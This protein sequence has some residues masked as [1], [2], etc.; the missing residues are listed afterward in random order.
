MK[1]LI[2]PGR[3]SACLALAERGRSGAWWHERGDSCG[4]PTATFEPLEES[5][6]RQQDSP[7]DRQIRDPGRDR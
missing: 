3:C 1:P 7:R 4:D 6:E 5:A 2:E